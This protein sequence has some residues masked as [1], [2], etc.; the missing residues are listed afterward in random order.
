MVSI[1]P[2]TIVRN[3][4]ARKM[5]RLMGTYLQEMRGRNAPAHSRA[6]TRLA[7]RRP[8]AL[9]IIKTRPAPSVGVTIRF[10]PVSSTKEDDETAK[11]SHELLRSRYKSAAQRVRGWK[12]EGRGL[13]IGHTDIFSISNLNCRSSI[14]DLQS[15]I[16]FTAT[17]SSALAR[18]LVFCFPPAGAP[19]SFP[20]PI[21]ILSILH[22]RSSILN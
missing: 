1:P 14:F 11:N 3:P 12:I 22:F 9:A 6:L 16:F 5:N 19:L 7:L 20:S 21:S 4:K 13:R 8:V 17:A 10:T 18:L 2:A 15:S